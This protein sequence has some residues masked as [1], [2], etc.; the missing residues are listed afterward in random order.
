MMAAQER[1]ADTDVLVAL[2]AGVPI[3]RRPFAALGAQLGMSEDAML[4]RLRVAFDEGIARRFGAVFDARR[5]GYRSTLCALELEPAELDGVAAR[6]VPLEGVTHCYLRG[7]PAELD[8]DGPGGPHGALAPN[9]WFTYTELADAFDDGLARVRDLAAPHALLVLPAAR[10]FKIDVVLGPGQRDRMESFPGRARR[11]AVDDGGD[12]P[13]RAFTETE[14]RV[15]RDMQGA[16]PPGPAPFDAI[17]AR[18]GYEADAF[19]ALLRGWEGEGVLR[20]VALIL[21]HYNAGFKA[22]AMCVWRVDAE[23]VVAAG[24]ALAACP[25]VTHCYERVI[26]PGFPYNIYAMIHTAGWAE[27]RALFESIEARAGLADGRMLCS[28]R[29]Y[30]KTSPSYFAAGTAK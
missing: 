18:N 24:R 2:Q 9:L 25:E 8:G 26:A 6:I 22:N 27:T 11:A 21:R 13:F 12:E 19:I 23:R 17:A 7:W 3:E 15:V 28:L 29:E 1:T 30:K 10:R 5:L 14:K 20:R 4:G 16:I